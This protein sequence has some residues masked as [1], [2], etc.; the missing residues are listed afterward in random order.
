MSEVVIKL[1]EQLF[2]RVTKQLCKETKLN[3]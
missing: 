1:Q 2:F 3:I